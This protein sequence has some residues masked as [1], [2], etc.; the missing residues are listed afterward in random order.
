VIQVEGAR[1]PNP[2]D[3][4][5]TDAALLGNRGSNNTN[6]SKLKGKVHQSHDAAG[7]FRG[8]SYGH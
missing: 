7:E 4:Y 1:G 3:L 5:V 8:V 6:H 2:D